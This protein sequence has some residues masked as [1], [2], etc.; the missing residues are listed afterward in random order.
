MSN[1]NPVVRSNALEAAVSFVILD[2]ISLLPSKNDEVY[3][4]F[5]LIHIR[6]ISSEFSPPP[7]KSGVTD[8]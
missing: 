4:G 5:S 7:L 1:H 2:G 6:K 8:F 3:L